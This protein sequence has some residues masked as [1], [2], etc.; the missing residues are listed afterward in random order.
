MQI[1][2]SPVGEETGP[3]LADKIYD[4]M[5][6]H[7]EKRYFRDKFKPHEKK[8]SFFNSVDFVFPG[9]CWARIKEGCCE[10]VS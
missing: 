7:Q 10:L 1:I 9:L 6:Q 3:G 8:N 4:K 5:K 2:D